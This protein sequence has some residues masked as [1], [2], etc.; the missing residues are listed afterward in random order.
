M[1]IEPS[2]QQSDMS[3]KKSYDSESVH[4]CLKH[5]H[6][7]A[8]AAMLCFTAIVFFIRSYAHEPSA[9]EL[10]YEY[11]W[12]TDDPTDLWTS[13]HQFQRRI[14]TLSDI[15]QTQIIHY[16][17]VNGRSLVHA[18]EQAFTGHPIVF[19][20]LNTIMFLLLAALIVR[21]TA[22]QRLR[23][24]F[25]FWFAVIIALLFLFP[26]QQSLWTSVNL[27]LNYLWPAVLALLVLFVWDRI[28][29]GNTDRRLAWLIVPL[30]LVFGWTHEAF[31][32][33]VAGGMFFYYCFNFRRFRGMALVLAIPLWFSSAVMVFAPGNLNRFL[34]K[35]EGG[36][37]LVYVVANGF[38]NLLHLKII[39]I[40]LIAIIIFAIVG[41]RHML[42]NF[43]SRNTRLIWVFAIAFI[44]SMIANTAPY[45]HTFVE[46]SA[47]L[48]LLRL[49]STI[50]VFTTKAANIVAVIV[51][52]LFVPQ[53]IVLARDTVTNYT[54]QHN[55]LEEY[56]NSPDGIVQAYFPDI[57]PTSRPYIRTWPM[58]HHTLMLYTKWYNNVYS[59][60]K[61]PALFLYHDDYMAVSNPNVFFTEE[62]RLPGNAGVYKGNQGI[63]LWQN[64]DSVRAGEDLVAELFPVDW[65]LDDAQLLLR[66]KFA[67]SPGSYPNEQVLTV[68][69][70]NTR[71]GIAYKIDPV[72]IRRI[73]SVN[74]RPKQ[75]LNYEK[76]Y[77]TGSRIQ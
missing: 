3:V 5:L 38:D 2:S 33:A 48:I 16:K 12:E 62:N 11:V 25:P 49:L 35:T 28:E 58:D 26:H 74:R 64:P 68:D 54:A 51:A 15:I 56:L 20:V 8:I 63:Y 70:I 27:G 73:K 42:K 61:K 4:A 36:S 76:D 7:W 47:L 59:M 23:A 10:I 9:D 44:F 60:G 17:E 53:Q 31:V 14:S 65:R 29:V 30:A 21:Y 46:L 55:M 34:G 69:T 52:C 75:L 18:V 40:L 67:L 6:Y 13:G 43:R 50:N 24:S 19:S 1:P 71:F 22:N 32:V 66:L 45:S 77:S 37:N 41:K 39:W 72:A 57:A